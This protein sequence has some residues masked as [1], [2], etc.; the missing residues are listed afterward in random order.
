MLTASLYIQQWS[1]KLPIDKDHYDD[2]YSECFIL[3]RSEHN[4]LYLMKQQFVGQLKAI[5][6]SVVVTVSQFVTVS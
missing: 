4:S 5:T 6:S 2:W 3:Y 1:G